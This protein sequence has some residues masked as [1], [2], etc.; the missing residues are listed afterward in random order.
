MEILKYEILPE[1]CCSFGFVESVLFWVILV[2]Y[3]IDIYIC[4]YIYKV[5][6]VHSSFVTLT[7]MFFLHCM[8][9]ILRYEKIFS[10]MDESIAP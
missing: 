2:T 3:N 7:V 8:L 10:E 9:K 6:Y 1:T 4:M 5:S